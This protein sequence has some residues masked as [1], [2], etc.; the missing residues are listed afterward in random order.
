MKKFIVLS[1]ALMSLF[2]YTK[3]ANAAL[4]LEPYVGYHLAGKAESTGFEEDF[5]GT[6]VGGRIGY[7]NFGF[8]MGLNLQKGTLDIDNLSDD[9]EYTTY[10]AFIGYNFPILVRAWAEFI[11]SGS[12]DVGSTDI[13][14]A[15][16]TRLG[17]GFT[18]LPFVSINLEM[19]QPTF[20]FDAGSDLDANSYLLSVSLPFTI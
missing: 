1:V 5:S 10:G 13:D 2:Y 18:A 4:L 8:M 9:L 17:V 16:G 11:I 14:K 12:G 20:E 7:Q 19:S 15:K 3:N 6:A